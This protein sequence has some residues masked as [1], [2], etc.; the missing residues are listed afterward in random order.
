MCIVDIINHM[1][2]VYKIFCPHCFSTL[3]KGSFLENKS[4]RSSADGSQQ[5]GEFLSRGNRNAA[6]GISNTRITVNF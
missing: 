4:P 1:K 3:D 2:G 6:A 5:E